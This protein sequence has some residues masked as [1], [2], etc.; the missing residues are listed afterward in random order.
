M[1]AVALPSYLIETRAGQDAMTL[2]ETDVSSFASQSVKV[3]TD[4]SH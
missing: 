2:M 4:I 3:R 1:A